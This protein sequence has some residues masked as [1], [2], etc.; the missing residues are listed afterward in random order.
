MRCPAC[1]A[2]NAEGATVCASCGKNMPQAAAPSAAETAAAQPAAR[3]KGRRLSKIAVFA[4]IAAAIAP[5]MQVLRDSA[6]G[7]WVS[8]DPAKSYLV[9]TILD[10]GATVL[11]LAAIVAGLIALAQVVV[12]SGELR[13][14]ALAVGGLILG[15]GGMLGSMYGNAMSGA[16]GEVLSAMGGGGGIYVWQ[17]TAVMAG[18]AIVAEIVVSL[19]TAPAASAAG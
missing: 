19:V 8:A 2:E 15:V 9:L 4:L 12:R 16:A 3:P 14:A 6:G 13:G 17:T 5:S 11:L 18:A 7:H 10:S 1:N